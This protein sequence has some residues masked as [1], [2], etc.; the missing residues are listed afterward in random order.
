MVTDEN[1]DV[2]KQISSFEN[3]ISSGCTAI[4]AVAFD[5][6]GISDMAKEGNGERNLCHD[7]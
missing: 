1:N 7:L 5:P 4:M 6:D 3:F 2:N